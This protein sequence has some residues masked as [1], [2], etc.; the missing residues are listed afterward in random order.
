MGYGG[1]RVEFYTANHYANFV[2]A[3]QREDAARVNSIIQR[4]TNVPASELLRQREE[5]FRAYE[6]Q[7][8]AAEA[9]AR[10]EEEA[11]LERRKR[12]DER[13]QRRIASRGRHNSLSAPEVATRRARLAHIN[14]LA[15][16]RL[17][18]EAAYGNTT[19]GRVM[20]QRGCKVEYPV[21]RNNAV[22][23]P[24]VDRDR[25]VPL[26]PVLDGTSL[27]PWIG[28][29][30]TH[31]G[32]RERE[33]IAAKQEA[34]YY[35]GTPTA[36]RSADA[37]AKKQKTLQSIAA[38]YAADQEEGPQ[39]AAPEDMPSTASIHAA[40]APHEDVA[41]EDEADTASVFSHG[42]SNGPIRATGNMHM[43][44]SSTKEGVQLHLSLYGGAMTAPR[45]R[46][47]ADQVSAKSLTLPELSLRLMKM[48]VPNIQRW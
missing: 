4:R 37:E 27:P 24:G 44:T 21:G 20:H 36:P 33:H 22:Y 41:A 13:Q 9:R 17:R 14:Q 11:A 39:Q 34:R 1:P 31:H 12:H 10:A 16:P 45:A 18:P 3:V 6:A 46:R 32:L 25:I 38:A 47:D 30:S 26:R 48:Q 29:Y 7:Q 19:Y 23:T 15:Q 35:C 43:C 28:S 2:S 5:A 42:S 8:V 40:A